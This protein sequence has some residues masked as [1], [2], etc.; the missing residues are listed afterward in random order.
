MENAAAVGVVDSAS[1]FRDEGLV[2]GI[3]SQRRRSLLQRS[4]R[5][6]FHA[7]ERQAVIAFAHF[8]N[9]KDVRMIKTGGIALGSDQRG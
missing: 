5:R 1:D 2:A 9:R 4:A 7:E 3:V 8:V 6:E